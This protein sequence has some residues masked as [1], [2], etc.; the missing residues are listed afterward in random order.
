MK[1]AILYIAFIFFSFFA[2]NQC[3]AF[4]GIQGVSSTQI[5]NNRSS[6]ATLN[7][8]VKTCNCKKAAKGFKTVNTSNSLKR[9]RKGVK[10]IL[11][12]AI[13]GGAGQINFVFN[14]V[15]K[16][17]FTF[18]DDFVDLSDGERAPPLYSFL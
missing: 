17:L 14:E 16:L 6:S 13:A 1:M 12:A 5:S 3:F 7:A 9:N 18:N 2:G 11:Y 15:I 4:S 10:P 8:K